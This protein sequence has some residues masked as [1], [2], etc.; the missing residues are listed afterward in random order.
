MKKLI[1]LL[2]LLTIFV[3]CKKET[4]APHAEQEL[5]KDKKWNAYIHYTEDSIGNYFVGGGSIEIQLIDSLYS[6]GTRID[7]D[8]NPIPATSTNNTYTLHL[9]TKQHYR[10]S[11]EEL[12]YWI[13]VRV[14]LFT[15]A[16]TFRVQTF[17]KEH[18]FVEGNNGYVNFNTLP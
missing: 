11:Y 14:T 3:S 16:L 7:I 6:N 13:R 17:Y 18:T 4:L 12:R 5:P 10:K 2:T 1:L 15:P 9:L 8:S